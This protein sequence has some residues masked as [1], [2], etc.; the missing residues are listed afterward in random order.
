[1]FLFLKIIN[2]E[3]LI[4]RLIFI[5]LGLFNKYLL[6]RLQQLLQDFTFIQLTKRLTFIQQ[7]CAQLYQ[8]FFQQKI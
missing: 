6:K 2:I 1:M 8:L 4:F 3:L 7:G 5:P